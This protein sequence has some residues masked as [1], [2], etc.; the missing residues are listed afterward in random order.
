MKTMIQT[1]R[2]RKLFRAGPLLLACLLWVGCAEGAYITNYFDTFDGTVFNPGNHYTLVSTTPNAVASNNA[3]LFIV[4]TNGAPFSGNSDV[5]T[6]GSSSLRLPISGVARVEMSLNSPGNFGI[7]SFAVLDNS[8]PS[9]RLFDQQ[10]FLALA[11]ANNN[12]SE[13]W[14]IIGNSNNVG[15]ANVFLTSAYTAEHI[16]SI[17]TIIRDSANTFTFTLSDSNDTVIASASASYAFTGDP[18]I[19]FGNSNTSDTR[20]DN[21]VILVPEP[22]TALFLLGSGVLLWRHRC[23]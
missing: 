21:F 22:T 6:T 13:E 19:A 5:R 15:L 4:H 11:R 14:R 7:S 10:N 3:A 16:T 2:S 17:L 18:Y 12:F 9:S 8:L 1:L 23:K 20:F